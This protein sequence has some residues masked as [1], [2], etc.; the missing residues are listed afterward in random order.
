VLRRL[1]SPIGGYAAG[2]VTIVLITLFYQ[3]EP[4]FKVTTVV[5]TY[6]LAIL[7]ASAIWGLGVSVFMS[8]ISTLVCD[9]FF[10]P[11]VG[12]FTVQDPH[13]YVTLVS[14]LITSVIGS[15]L[16]AR[17]RRQAKE[18]NKRRSEVEKLYQFSRDL[19]SARNP[20]ELLI[21]IPKRIVESFKVGAA[22]LYL[23]EKQ[24]IFRSDIDDPHLDA[25]RLKSAVAREDVEADTRQGSC[26][27]PMRIG[28]RVIGSFG[29]SGQA[30]SRQTL[31]AIS[32]LIASAIDRAQ[33]I[34]LVGKVEAARESE[35]LKS[36][37]LDAVTHDFRTPLTSIKGSVT[38]LLGDVKLNKKQRG[39]L[40]T[41]IDEEC[42]RINRLVGEAAEMSRLEAGDVKLD[43]KSHAVDELIAGALADCE[44][45]RSARPI[46]VEMEQTDLRVHAD[47]S[48]AQK[49]LVHLIENAHL[50][51]S[52]GQPITISTEKRGD[53]V[54]LSIADTG[55]GIEETEVG[56]IFDRFY[57][58][59]DHRY[60]VPGTGM[61]LSIAKAIVEA[62]GGTIE[63]VS[64]RGHGSVFTFSLPIDR[65]EP[66]APGAK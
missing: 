2:S 55:P 58:S 12:Q 50:Y 24:K 20:I 37:L 4:N 35:R 64:Q 56:Q 59:K 39:E 28:T 13:D 52:P 8:V 29:I 6:L 40:L 14:F 18:A 7:V 19:L 46:R 38:S 53:F 26:F 48:W 47:L 10:F 66:T 17:A 25:I 1:R 23:P 22:A 44:S 54:F 33:A 43:L 5:L 65:G 57:R 11:P 32:A 31:E 51:S 61:G 41:V 3:R 21:E 45:V 9:Y 15:D 49:V 27:I 42:D 63:G 62:H 60:R 16:S 36:V 34:E 30:L